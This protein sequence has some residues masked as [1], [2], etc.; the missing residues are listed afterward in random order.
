MT[1]ATL[2]R[3]PPMGLNVGGNLSIDDDGDGMMEGMDE[4]DN[5]M[6]R[7]RGG[8]SSHSRNNQSR[9]V[10]TSASRGQLVIAEEPDG[11]SD[12][13]DYNGETAVDYSNPGK[14]GSSDGEGDQDRDTGDDQEQETEQDNDQDM[15]QDDMQN[16]SIPSYDE[17]QH[18][19]D[20]NGRNGTSG[21]SAQ[22][23]GGKAGSVDSSGLMA[24]P[25]HTGSKAAA[26]G[27]NGKSFVCDICLKTFSNAANMRRHRVRH[28]GV[29]PFECRFC[30]KRFF[31][32]DH[33]REHMNH[34]HNNTQMEC[35]FCQQVFDKE[36]DLF[37]HVT[38]DHD[39]NPRE[40]HCHYCSFSATTLGRYLWHLTTSHPR[41]NS[42]YLDS[43]SGEPLSMSMAPYTLD[44][45]FDTTETPAARSRTA[46]QQH[47]AYNDLP[48][49]SR[50]YEP[51]SR[52]E[53]DGNASPP[54]ETTHSKLN[55]ALNRGSGYYEETG[56]L[57]A[58]LA[59]K[60]NGSAARRPVQY[61]SL[62]PSHLLDG[63]GGAEDLSGYARNGGEG[64]HAE[65]LSGG[66]GGYPENSKLAYALFPDRIK[67]MNGATNPSGTSSAAVAA[68]A[69]A[70]MAAAAARNAEMGGMPLSSATGSSNRRKSKAPVRM[71]ASPDDLSGQPA[72]AAGA[73]NPPRGTKREYPYP[74]ET[75]NGNSD[76]HYSPM[77]E[78]VMSHSHRDRQAHQAEDLS[79]NNPP[80]AAAVP[81]SRNT[82]V[83]QRKASTNNGGPTPSANGIA[84]TATS[85][86]G[87]AEGD[88]EHKCP[89][90]L[91]VYPDNVMYLL[92]KML[93]V[94]NQPYKCA[95]CTTVY[96]NRY[97]FYAHVVNH[98]AT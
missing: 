25:N 75:R 7:G 53:R 77:L 34:K 37:H 88:S 15:D 49:K 46:P 54:T 79:V 10:E 59:G 43:S 68:A 1:T 30:Q 56:N 38:R 45:D 92:H 51:Y 52:R 3:G 50:E 94:R 86:A 57:A 39:V 11:E 32:K 13:G 84:N 97:E 69:A 67:K 18:M 41:K 55:G 66:Y 33:M 78:E 22:A 9:R 61:V 90:C 24:A 26:A 21:G 47:P 19:N 81:S 28:S 48:T 89:Y 5:N 82:G 74:E 58:A 4:E 87:A 62:L 31:R 40:L 36:K 14:Q 17:Y 64:G 12:E 95:I 71:A 73:E 35:Y 42:H 20:R 98:R 65:D 23:Y 96:P 70:A 93:H 85:G 27:K 83:I 63:Q 29:K 44:A 6:S 2:A 8:H 60:S 72:D 76:S 91:I 80:A 16:G